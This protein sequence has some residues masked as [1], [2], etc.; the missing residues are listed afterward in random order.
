MRFI[1][2]SRAARRSFPFGIT[3]L[4]VAPSRVEHRT[5][6]DSERLTVDQRL[7]HLAMGGVHDAAE[8]G[9]GD[10]HLLGGLLLVEAVQIP[11]V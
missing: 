1:S 11:R 2:A 6:L 5:A 4:A 10:T 8:G 9:F 3:S 7:G